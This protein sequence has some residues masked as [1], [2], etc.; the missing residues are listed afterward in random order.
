MRRCEFEASAIVKSN[1][2]PSHD[3]NHVIQFGSSWSRWPNC[4]KMGKWTGLH[5]SRRSCRFL[6]FFESSQNR[7][8]FETDKKHAVIGAEWHTQV[9]SC[10]ATIL[11][12]WGKNARHVH[13]ISSKVTMANS[14]RGILLCGAIVAFIRRASSI[15]YMTY[16]SC[17]LQA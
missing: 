14:C 5:L 13:I 1:I 12:L 16:I 3:Y 15:K 17:N 4:H 11:P 8:D 9:R 6:S 2:H 7:H 10:T